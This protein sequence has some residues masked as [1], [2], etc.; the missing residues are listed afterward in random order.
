MELLIFLGLW[1]VCGIVSAV[2]SGNRGGS[3]G[4]GCLWFMLGIVLGPLGV[5]LAAVAAGSGYQCPHCKEDVKQGASICPHCR[6]GLA[7]AKLPLN[8]HPPD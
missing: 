3:A 6:T 2:I 8:S 5:L 7:S 4:V 1:F